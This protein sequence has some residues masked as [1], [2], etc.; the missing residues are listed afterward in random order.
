VFAGRDALD[1]LRHLVKSGGDKRII[2]RMAVRK[3]RTQCVW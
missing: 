1:D 2:A 3:T